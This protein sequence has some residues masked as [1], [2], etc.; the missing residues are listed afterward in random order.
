MVYDSE[1]EMNEV[2]GALDDNSFI[3]SQKEELESFRSRIQHINEKF[4]FVST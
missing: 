2:M 3:R 1:Q 4:S